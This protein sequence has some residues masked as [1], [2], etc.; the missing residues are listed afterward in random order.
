MNLPRVTIVI[1][2]Y[3]YAEYVGGCI[4]S[5]LNQ[6]YEGF[7]TVCVVDDGSTDGSWEIIKHQFSDQVFESCVDDII[8]IQ[9]QVNGK[10]LIAIKQENSGASAARNTAIDHAWDITDIYAIL[11]ADDEYYP[12]KVRFCV[13]KMLCDIQNIGVVYADYDIQYTRENFTK[14]EFKE[15]YNGL[16]LRQNC[17]VHSNALINKI[18][19][20][21]VKEKGEYYDTNLHGPGDSQFIGCSEDYDLWL[22]IA[23]RFMIVHLPIPLAMARETGRNQTSNVTRGSEMRTQK[24]ISDKIE[25]RQQ[26]R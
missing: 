20:E 12:S 23:E 1:A 21:A 14:R 5:A 24:I 7:V 22:R 26:K 2:S 19:L 25:S 11:D 17:I 15:P 4:Q 8:V 13:D 18:A 6:D 9:E 16:R 10:A 3:N